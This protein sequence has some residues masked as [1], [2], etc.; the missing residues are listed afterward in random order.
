[1]NISTVNERKSMKL[2]P[3]NENILIKEIQQDNMTHGGIHLPQSSNHPTKLAKV[4]DLGTGMVTANGTRIPFSVIIGD[5]V[6]LNSRA[7]KEISANGEKF[8]L[9]VERDILAIVRENN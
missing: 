5:I 6:M 2:Q 4:I 9:I 1:M 3:I 8:G 7:G